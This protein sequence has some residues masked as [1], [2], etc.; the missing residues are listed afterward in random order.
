VLIPEVVTGILDI[1]GTKMKDLHQPFFVNDDN[2]DLSP[3]D[4]IDEL[5]LQLE[6][7]EPPPSLVNTILASVARLPRHE[8]LTD[9]AETGALEQEV[10]GLVV[11]NTHLQ[12]S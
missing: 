7:V 1:K 4:D 12:P 11:R 3:L 8:F 9:V 6:V 2:D 5:F 10:D